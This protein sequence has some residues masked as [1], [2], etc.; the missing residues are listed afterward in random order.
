MWHVKINRTEKKSLNSSFL[1]EIVSL[2]YVLILCP[3]FL[4]FTAVPAAI[5]RGN[6]DTTDS[7]SV[8]G[9]FN[10]NNESLSKC[11][12]S[13][14]SVLAKCFVKCSLYVLKNY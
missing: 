12:N 7:G 3:T 14:I 11:F 13:F 10:I 8:A 6:D 9:K 1:L 2:F 4:I 5:G